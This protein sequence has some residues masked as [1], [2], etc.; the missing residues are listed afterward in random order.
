M[1]CV[2]LINLYIVRNI[3]NDKVLNTSGAIASSLCV[4]GWGWHAAVPLVPLE[5]YVCIYACVHTQTFQIWV[6]IV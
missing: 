2:V 4:W 3:C 1:I 5:M 6:Y